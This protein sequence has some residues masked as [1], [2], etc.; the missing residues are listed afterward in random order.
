MATIINYK[1]GI[2]VMG[3]TYTIKTQLKELGGMWNKRLTDKDGKLMEGWVFQ[4]EKEAQVRSI[5][6]GC[7]M[8]DAPSRP[9]RDASKSSKPVAKLMSIVDYS[10]KSIAV[11]GNTV[12]LKDQFKE[13]GGRW[14]RNLVWGEFAG[15]DKIGGWIFPKSKQSEVSALIG[16]ECADEGYETADEGYET[17]EDECA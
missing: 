1:K 14:N 2:V 15:D 9:P 13:L 12:P 17:A 5:L 10:E 7:P 3:N 16:I 4:K 6:K 8:C 11:F